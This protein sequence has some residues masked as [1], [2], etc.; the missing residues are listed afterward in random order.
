M[1]DIFQLQM[2]DMNIVINGEQKTVSA[3]ITIAQLLDS[4]KIVPATIVAEL[5]E[6][7][8]LPDTYTSSSLLEGDRLEFIRFVGGG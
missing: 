2:H 7:I 6:V 5:N 3:G 8:V 1:S 4:F